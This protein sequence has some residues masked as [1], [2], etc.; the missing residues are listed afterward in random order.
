[1]SRRFISG[2]I[3][4]CSLVYS[5]DTGVI[6]AMVSLERSTHGDLISTTRRILRLGPNEL[7]VTDN[8]LICKNPNYSLC[9]AMLK[10]D[11]VY[12]IEYLLS[13]WEART[14][15][16]AYFVFKNSGSAISLCCYVKAPAGLSRLDHVREFNVLRVNESLA[17]AISDIERVKPSAR[18]VLTNCVVRRST[19]GSAYNIEFVA[20][21]PENE[22]EYDTLLRDMYVKKKRSETVMMRQDNGTVRGTGLERRERPAYKD[23]GVACD[24]IPGNRC[25]SGKTTSQCDR[26]CGRRVKKEPR[27][28]GSF[29]Y[30][31][32]CG[33]AGSL[34]TRFGKHALA[35]LA[36]CALLVL[37]VAVRRYVFM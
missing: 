17:V 25:C 15:N 11:V 31:E 16:V 6:G 27:L 3:S 18:G 29:V 32:D 33:R 36:V 5:Y 30:A 4:A 9:D 34:V 7:R 37:F 2:V 24:R 8:A 20:F 21:G 23:C 14:G 22:R 26:E 12:C 35:C 10:T 28:D 19:S 13:Y 1:M